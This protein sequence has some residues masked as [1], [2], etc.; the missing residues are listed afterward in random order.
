MAPAI[1]ILPAAITAVGRGRAVEGP[2]RCPIATLDPERSFDDLAAPAARP[3]RLLDRGTAVACRQCRPPDDQ[4]EVTV[5]EFKE[6]AHGRGHAESM[7]E[8]SE[9][10]IDPSGRSR[11]RSTIGSALD[12]Q[13]TDDIGIVFLR[14]RQE[15]AIDSAILEQFDVVGVELGIALGIGQQQRITAG[16]Q[17]PLGATHDVREDGIGEVGNGETD[18]HA[19]LTAETAARAFGR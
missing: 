13:R 6:V 9:Q 8:T 11:S 17:L 15:H 10:G 2:Q 16:P 14:E 4:R 12:A 7:V 19:P 1:N 5:A 3:Q 18:G